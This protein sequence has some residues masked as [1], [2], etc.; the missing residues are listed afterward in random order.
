MR[1]ALC[2]DQSPAFH[3]DISQKVLRLPEVLTTTSLSRSRLYGLIK[4]GKFPRQ[5]PLTGARSVG[6]L[7]SEIQAWISS[8][9]AAREG[10]R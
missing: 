9:A 4:A 10:G 5:V 3:P 7:A 8:R 2:S 1:H 6:W